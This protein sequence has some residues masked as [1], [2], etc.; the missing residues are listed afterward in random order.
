MKTLTPTAVKE[1][2]S[3]SQEMALLD[4]R[5]PGQYEEGH[6]FFAINLPYSRLEISAPKLLPSIRSLLVIMDHDDG[7]AERALRRLN[8]LGYSRIAILE[9]GAPGWAKAGYHL[10]KGMNVPSKT[11]GELV[12]KAF[13]TPTI[14]PQE[15]SDKWAQGDN[16]VILDGRT[17]NEFQ[18][19]SIPGGISCPNAELA[20]RVAKFA[21]DPNTSIIIN[22]AGRTRSIMGVE[23]L[24]RLEMKNSV[25]A[26]ENGTQ[27]WELAGLNLER[28]QMAGELPELNVEEMLHRQ[29]TARLFAKQR[30]IPFVDEERLSLW[31]D[32]ARALYLL[33]VRTKD[34][35]HSGHLSGATHAP[36][37]QL[38]QATDQ[39]IAVRGARIVLCDDLLL[40]AV[41]TAHWLRCMGH[42]VWVLEAL[43]KAFID[44]GVEDQSNTS[45]SLPT[46][47]PEEIPVRMDAGAR[48][49]D[50]SSSARYRQIHL[51][52]SIW[53]IRSQIP[54][55]NLKVGDKV[56]LTAADP[57]QAELFAV[58]LREEGIRDLSWLTGDIHAWQSAG[59]TTE[60]TPEYPPDEACIDFL[61]STHARHKGDLSAA[62]AYLSWET[63]LPEELDSQERN[64]I[65][66]RG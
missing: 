58:D 3:L 45:P 21:P 25:F 36:G 62:K 22:C 51:A 31:R 34:E 59:L 17:P 4:V 46:L 61:F 65:Q 38:V 12:E 10:F 40:R 28:G 32:E 54:H 19:M 26:L 53:S 18:R 48:L 20:L 9:G 37:G 33:D 13:H 30:E 8:C 41:I 27:G 50:V 47:S 2:I 66:P 52:R 63:G 56:I 44:Q 35:F 1:Q 57:L 6:P 42:E 15:L 60:S 16:L 39:W 55:L 14:T 49:I 24:R 43:R 23:S 64:I 5:E 29:T 11:L 7:V